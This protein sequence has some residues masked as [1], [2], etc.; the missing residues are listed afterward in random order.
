MKR[1]SNQHKLIF[2]I[3]VL[4]QGT[5]SI[6][7]YFGKLWEVFAPAR[8]LCSLI[9]DDL[10]IGFLVINIGLFIFGIGV[11]HFLI[12]KELAIG[13]TFMWIWIVI[14]LINGIGHP[15]WA[16]SEGSYMPG[17][18]TAPFLL[19]LAIYLATTLLNMR[20]QRSG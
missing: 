2:I 20:S 10:E 1:K 13:H 11:W 12:K 5:H 16:L 7:E 17:L 15:L 4:V 8:I 19:L 6:E 3:L 18:Y 14:E 9:S